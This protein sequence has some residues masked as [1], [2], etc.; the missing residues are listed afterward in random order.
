MGQGSR[1]DGVVL[2]VSTSNSSGS[3]GRKMHV[4]AVCGGGEGFGWVRRR[5]VRQSSD[6]TTVTGQT[7]LLKR[8][9]RETGESSRRITTS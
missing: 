1:R 5:S 3:A 4:C 8:W 6:G 9:S 2:V 7:R